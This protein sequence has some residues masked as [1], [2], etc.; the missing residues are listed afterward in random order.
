M[1]SNTH[2]RLIINADDYG[3][4][5]PAC[6]AI[7]E[8]SDK[9]LISSTTIMANLATD[10]QL[11]GIAY[12]TSVSTG[13]HINIVEGKPLSDPDDIPSLLNKNKELLS[14]KDL[15]IKFLSGGLNSNHIRIEMKAQY[16]RL[17]NAG[18]KISHADAHQHTHQLPFVGAIILKILQELG[19]KKARF[20]RVSD[21][22]SYRM[23]LLQLFQRMNKAHAKQFS[24]PEILITSLSTGKI[25]ISELTKS[26]SEAFKKAGC[27]EVM[28]HPA[29]DNSKTYLDRMG[30]Y[31]MWKGRE[32]KEFLTS[33]EI[34][35]IPYF[36]LPIADS[37][38]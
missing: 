20:G 12:M 25:E 5:Q 15:F 4:D 18:I 36:K 14:A 28:T 37:I 11:K 32:W 30:E 35:I 31:E 16:E 13:W 34:E 22:N 24:S 23:R 9:K 21:T 8:L 38:F 7:L 6:D 2:K 33:G 19:I 17:I 3:L 10:E 1:K 27:I 26:L 29:T